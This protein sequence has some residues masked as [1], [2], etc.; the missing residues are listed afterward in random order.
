MNKFLIPAILAATV[1][2][3][4]VF[5]LAPME[6][7]STVHTQI[8]A[9]SVDLFVTTDTSTQGDTG[10]ASTTNHDITCSDSVVFYAIEVNIPVNEA[11]DNYN[12]VTNTIL[13]D[14]RAPT[15]ADV[16]PAANNAFDDELINGAAGLGTGEFISLQSGNTLRVPIQETDANDGDD[17]TAAWNFL[18][19]ANT[20]TTCTIP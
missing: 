1:L 6:E 13:L 8:Q 5:A 14:A 18:I 3:A 2:V 7:A 4:G 12:L 17:A 19:L 10:G 20:G 11:Q 15:N 9:S 16:N